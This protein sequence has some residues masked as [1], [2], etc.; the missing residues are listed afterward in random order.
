MR[1]QLNAGATSETAQTWKTI[2]T[3]HTLIH[4]S[5]ANI[6]WW[7]WRTNDIQGPCGPKSFLI[8][9]LPVRKNPKKKTSPWKPVP[10]GDRTRVRCVTDAYDP[11]CST[12]VDN[13][14][15]ILRI[16]QTILENVDDGW[17]GF[18]DL[19]SGRK[20][21][22]NWYL[23]SVVNFGEDRRVQLATSTLLTS[24]MVPLG[25]FQFF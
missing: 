10:T 12:A 1:D 24:T 18:P 21:W 9:V 2:H 17:L 4:S 23:T 13:F 7:L 22:W 14:I 25:S 11:A 3:R 20:P 15:N 5:K 19:W 6:K 16:L 8:F